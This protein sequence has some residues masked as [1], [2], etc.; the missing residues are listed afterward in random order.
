MKIHQIHQACQTRQTHRIIVNLKNLLLHLLVPV[1]ACASLPAQV[2]LVKYDF[3]T[4]SSVLPSGWSDELLTARPDG[5]VST[6]GYGAQ[7]GKVNYYFRRSNVGS[8]QATAGVASFTLDPAE[9]IDLGELTFTL[10]HQNISGTVFDGYT[11]NYAVGVKIG[12]AP[13]TL[14]PTIKTHT[15]LPGDVDGYN[16]V[17]LDDSATFDLSSFSGVSSSITFSIYV[18]VTDIVTVNGAASA[19]NHTLRI[20]DI[21]VTGT[22]VP[23]P[24][25]T[26]LLA[27]GI[28]ALAMLV[29]RRMRR[30]AKQQA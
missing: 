19:S 17:V 6:A 1:A 10:G 23:E 2:T 28:A 9:A 4:A 12:T 21:M 24:A 14:L 16:G 8:T 27:G 15:A 29:C 3:N 22:A 13:E 30:W 11:I 25:T 18:Y 20:D 7:S 5:I 26:A